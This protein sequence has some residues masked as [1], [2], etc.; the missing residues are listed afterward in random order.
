MLICT[1]PESTFLHIPKTGGQSVLKWMRENGLPTHIPNIAPHSVGNTHAVGFKWCIV[2]NPYERMVSAY[3]FV[4]QFLEEPQSFEDFLKGKVNR[5]SF[6]LTPQV[7]FTAN[8]DTV[9]RFES[10]EEDFAQIQEFYGI[11]SALPSVNESTYE[12]P[13]QDYYDETTR[14]I[15]ETK[16]ADDFA[17]LSYDILGE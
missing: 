11:T 15:V 16:Y 4:S 1:N 10:L 12:Q 14:Q 13:W 8:A 5:L 3:V 6:W 7:E 17:Q 2:R 9:L